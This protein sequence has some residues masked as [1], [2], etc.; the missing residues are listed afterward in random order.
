[1]S[2]PRAFTSIIRA[3]LHTSVDKQGNA[4]E[5]QVEPGRHGKGRA[6]GAFRATEGDSGRQHMYLRMAEQR[7]AFSRSAQMRLAPERLAPRSETPFSFALPSSTPR[8]SHSS[9]TVLASPCIAAPCSPPATP[10][11]T[12]NPAHAMQ[13]HTLLTLFPHSPSF[14]LPYRGS[15]TRGQDKSASAAHRVRDNRQGKGQDTCALY[16]T[17]GEAKRGMGGGGAQGHLAPDGALK[18]APPQ[19]CFVAPSADKHGPR[20]VALCRSLH[21]SAH[22]TQD[23]GLFV[24]RDQRARQ[25]APTDRRN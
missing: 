7:S 24:Q 5:R 21:T 14:A 15:G 12:S 20:H 22:T 23:T 19:V 10:P 18:I 16:G 1:M 13:H 8:R 4:D 3:S 25:H 11:E 2:A 17:G 6:T 9:R